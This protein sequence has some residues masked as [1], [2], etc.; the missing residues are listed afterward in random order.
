MVEA[1]TCGA[2]GTTQDSL[3]EKNVGKETRER[4]ELTKDTNTIFVSLLFFQC[5]LTST[6]TSYEF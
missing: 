2:G 4:K 1:N 5:M 6:K 3:V